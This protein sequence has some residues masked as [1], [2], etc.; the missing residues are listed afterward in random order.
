MGMA[1]D[2]LKHFG[3]AQNLGSIV[4]LAAKNP[5]ILPSLVDSLTP[6][7]QAPEA[8][9]LEGVLGKFLSGAS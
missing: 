4:N 8:S 2:L 6:H 3:G 7:G 9:S 1:G 5:Q